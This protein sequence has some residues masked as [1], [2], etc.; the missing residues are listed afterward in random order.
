M[1][2]RKLSK[3]PE[4]FGKGVLRGVAAPESANNA[5][6]AQKMVPLL[7]LG[8]PFEFDSVTDERFHDSW[9]NPGPMLISQ[10][11]EL[12]W[13]L[14]ASMFV[15]NIFLIVIKSTAGWRLGEPLK[16]SIFR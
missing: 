10:H 7:S 11:P 9:N 8:I 13:G 5:S 3:H 4:E 14:I 16:E 12:F 1:V 2:S 15:G 6:M